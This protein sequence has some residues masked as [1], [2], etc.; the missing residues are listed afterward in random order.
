MGQK[1]KI[2]L[3][4]L[5]VLLFSSLIIIV[6][7]QNANV[8][9]GKKYTDTEK[10]LARAKQEF[11]QQGNN[12]QG[13]I[14]NLV[15]EKKEIQRQ[16]MDAG[17]ELESVIVE[18]DEVKKRYKIVNKEK[19]GL[20]SKIQVLAQQQEG[21]DALKNKADVLDK[22]IKFLKQSKRD[23][24]SELRKVRQENVKL[25][26][27]IK[28]NELES[29]VTKAKKSSKTVKKEEVESEVWSVDLPPIIVSP[30]SL[31]VPTE[32]SAKSSSIAVA[33]P[34]KG[35]ILNINA[36]YNFA[37][38]DLGKDVGLKQ[39]MI[40]EV[41]RQDNLIGK[42]EVIQVRPEISACDIIQALD[43]FQIGDIVR[44]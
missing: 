36:E 37:V 24:E 38:I 33:S 16:L 14:S 18:S 5:I 12:L 17:A 25:D 39:G 3:I 44:Y 21:L 30:Q 22:D 26:K 9:L 43:S 7:M 23:L 2:I 27:K 20:L 28:Q 11:A 42:V 19:D 35:E 34:L 4:I 29:S 41:Y 15:A 31:A 6:A 8:A 10:K 13:K 1:L 32:A 40:F